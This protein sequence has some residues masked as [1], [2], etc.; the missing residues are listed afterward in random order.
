MK[1]SELIN[2]LTVLQQE[3]GDLEILITDG[4]K[5]VCYRGDYLLNIWKEPDGE[6]FIDIGVGGLQE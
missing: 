2:K 5:A 4:W 6:L 1:A 3:F